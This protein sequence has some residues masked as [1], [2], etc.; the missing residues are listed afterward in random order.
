MR[1]E[2]GCEEGETIDEVTQFLIEEA[3]FVALDIERANASRQEDAADRMLA[4]AKENL[5][6]ARGGYAG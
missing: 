5:A 6:R 1:C 3:A 4:L 2:C